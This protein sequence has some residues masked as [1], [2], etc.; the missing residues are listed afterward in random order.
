MNWLARGW[1]SQFQSQFKKTSLWLEIGKSVAGNT[2][3]YTCTGLASDSWAQLRRVGT[4]LWAIPARKKKLAL[5]IR[6]R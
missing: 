5:A 3:T 4:L 2:A 1:P 6:A